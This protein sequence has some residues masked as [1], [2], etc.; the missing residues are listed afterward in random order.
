M[1]WSSGFAR[2]GR[3]ASAV[4]R[5]VLGCHAAAGRLKK[6]AHALGSAGCPEAAMCLFDGQL[7]LDPDR[8]I[9]IDGE[10]EKQSIQ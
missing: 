8:L 5:L 2:S 4:A 10:T 7:D 1:K 6:S 3:C 9:F